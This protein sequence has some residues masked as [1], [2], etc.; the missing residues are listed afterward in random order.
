M[1]NKE[2]LLNLTPRIT[3][4]NDDGTHNAYYHDV[5]D[6]F[7][8]GCDDYVILYAHG[9]DD[10]GNYCGDAYVFGYDPKKEQFFEVH[11]SHCSCY[12]LEQ[13]W[14][15]EYFE[16]LELL[17]AYLLKLTKLEWGYGPSAE[18]IAFLKENGIEL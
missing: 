13:C 5:C 8:I 18:F 14:E 6:E 10:V 9:E 11:A 3:G 1:L 15:P 7:A 17:N 4:F 16:T 2:A 12:G